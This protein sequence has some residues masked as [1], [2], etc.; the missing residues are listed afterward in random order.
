[1]AELKVTEL[2]QEA[3]DEMVKELQLRKNEE[4]NRISDQIK[5]AKSLGDFSENAELDAAKEEE[6]NNEK[7]IAELEAILKSVKITVAT[8]YK[9]YDY[10][11]DA[12]YEYK[13]VGGA[14]ASVLEGKI[15]V[16]SPLGVALKG[17]KKGDDVFVKTS[18]TDG[19]KIK[20]LSIK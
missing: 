11:D 17:K 20:I 18:A 19:Y 13:L 9:I 1:M 4:R 8:T 10:E 12:E 3:Y 7:K 15:S 5:Y 14:E 6:A 2:T 16:D